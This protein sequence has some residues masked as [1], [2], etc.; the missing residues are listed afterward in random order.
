MAKNIALVIEDTP[1]NRD[2]FER[3]ITAAGFE[4]LGA[5]NGKQALEKLQD[6]EALTLAVIDM[7]IPDISGLQL[8][9]MLR[10]R[11]PEAC[12]IVATMHDEPSL[13]NSAFQRGCDIFLVKPH[14]FME[15]FKQLQA[16]GA[17]G[18]RKEGHQVID[19][20]GMRRHIASTSANSS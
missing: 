3:L 5:D 7:E 4:V 15:L 20:H 8:T 11:Y 17:D 18:L 12:L 14:G 13:M 6:V 2:F 1:A 16:K 10:Q 9:T 19:I